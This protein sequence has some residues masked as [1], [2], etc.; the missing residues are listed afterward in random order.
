[1]EACNEQACKMD[2][3]V[4]SS[5][6]ACLSAASSSVM[7]SA[8]LKVPLRSS[9]KQTAIT[10]TL[11][12]ADKHFTSSVDTERAKS[13]QAVDIACLDFMSL[14]TEGLNSKVLKRLQQRGLC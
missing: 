2:A 9:G 5:D 8:V 11:Q 3:Q 1:M 4:G 6:Q 7:W 12:V 13:L 10:S 14:M